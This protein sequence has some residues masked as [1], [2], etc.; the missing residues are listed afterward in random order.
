MGLRIG[1][2][3]SGGTPLVD[4]QLVGYVNTTL[5]FKASASGSV[6]SDTAPASSYSYGV[7]LLYNLGYEISSHSI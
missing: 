4:A 6:S 7:Y 1:G 2:K 3:I 5:R